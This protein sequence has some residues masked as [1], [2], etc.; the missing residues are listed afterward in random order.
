MEKDWGTWMCVC[1]TWTW[2]KQRGCFLTNH[3]FL[4]CLCVSVSMFVYKE[5]LSHLIK[6]ST[7]ASQPQS[8]YLLTS[9]SQR[10][11][12]SQ[13]KP[14]QQVV[15]QKK[16]LIEQ[17]PEVPRTRVGC[18]ICSLATNNSRIVTVDITDVWWSLLVLPTG[19]QRQSSD[20]LAAHHSVLFFRTEK[21]SR[22]KKVAGGFKKSV[23]SIGSYLPAVKG[24][25]ALAVAFCHVLFHHARKHWNKLLGHG[26]VR[27]AFN[28]FSVHPFFVFFFLYCCLPTI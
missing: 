14:H 19:Y 24:L 28:L 26:L 16:T 3:S 13:L 12:A 23:S 11:A 27:I 17:S 20:L 4:P 8:C 22:R 9:T 25:A 2:R 15:G 18:H 21:W 1:C 5:C 10:W 6:P 7:A